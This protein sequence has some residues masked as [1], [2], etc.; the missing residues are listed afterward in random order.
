MWPLLTSFLPF[1]LEILFQLP[2]LLPR[3]SKAHSHHHALG[4]SSLLRV[5]TC[6]HQSHPV[7]TLRGLLYNHPPHHLLSVSAL[8][9]RWSPE[10]ATPSAAVLAAWLANSRSPLRSGPSSFISISTHVLLWRTDTMMNAW[11]LVDILIQ[12]TRNEYP[13][14]P[15]NLL[16]Y[17]LFP[18]NSH[19]YMSTT[20]WAFCCC[21]LKYIQML[22]LLLVKYSFHTYFLYNRYNLHSVKY[23]KIIVQTMIVLLASTLYIQLGQD[24]AYYHSQQGKM[25]YCT[26][27]V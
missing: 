17:R 2:D 4:W 3:S 5:P 19:F 26:F 18:N 7:L 1:S 13:D 27:I 24:L 20:K 23:C 9:P 21:I 11:V 14:T 8:H 16:T 10:R 25:R 6:R 12:K 15:L 22:S